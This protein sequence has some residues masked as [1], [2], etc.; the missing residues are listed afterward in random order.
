MF[1]IETIEPLNLVAIAIVARLT[2]T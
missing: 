1:R 2:Q